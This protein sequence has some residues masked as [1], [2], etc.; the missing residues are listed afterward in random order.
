MNNV[1]FVWYK[2]R[3]YY[4]FFWECPRVQCLWTCLINV[5]FQKTTVSL[6]KDPKNFLFGFI[7]LEGILGLNLIIL[8][9]KK[10]ISLCRQNNLDPSWSSCVSYLS[11]QKRID[12]IS[13]CSL[14]PKKAEN[15]KQKWENMKFIFE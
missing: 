8:Y 7:K 15:L 3:P 14:S 10:Y 5:V 6:Q 2:E 12:N 1:L 4:I 9:I 11:Y 13:L